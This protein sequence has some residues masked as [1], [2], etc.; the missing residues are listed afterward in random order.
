MRVWRCETVRLCIKSLVKSASSCGHQ[1]KHY[2]N[3]DPESSSSSSSL[4]IGSRTP[5]LPSD[6]FP[7]SPLT[8]NPPPVS[9]HNTPCYGSL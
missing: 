2:I 8:L 9:S 7:Y 4:V 3:Q 1:E 5:V 6:W